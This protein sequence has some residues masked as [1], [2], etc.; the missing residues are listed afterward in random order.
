MLVIKIR[1]ILFKVSSSN[2]VQ[3][4]HLFPL[5]SCLNALVYFI[6]LIST[7]HISESVHAL[8]GLE[9]RVQFKNFVHDYLTLHVAESGRVDCSVQFAPISSFHSAEHLFDWVRGL[10]QNVVIRQWNVLYLFVH[11]L[12]SVQGVVEGIISTVR[13]GY[14]R[15][16]SYFIEYFGSRSFSSIRWCCFLRPIQLFILCNYVHIVWVGSFST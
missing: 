14:G 12:R 7:L 3:Y 2:H 15:V 10:F 1:S 8:L 11:V 16:R 13:L 5:H 6:T 4:S 9:L